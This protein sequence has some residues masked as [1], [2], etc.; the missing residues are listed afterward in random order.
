MKTPRKPFQWTRA[1]IRDA[2]AAIAPICAKY[3]TGPAWRILIVGMLEGKMRQ[4]RREVTI[5]EVR[6]RKP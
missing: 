2:D 3:E 1:A 4:Q 6:R 5:R